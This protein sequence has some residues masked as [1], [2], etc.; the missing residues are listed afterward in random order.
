MAFYFEHII[1]HLYRR[2]TYTYSEN[3]THTFVAGVHFSQLESDQNFG[4]ISA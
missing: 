2:Y 1:L 3:V 4:E